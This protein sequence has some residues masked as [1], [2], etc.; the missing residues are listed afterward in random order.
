MDIKTIYWVVASGYLLFGLLLMLFQRREAPSRRV[1]HWV[2][3]K[4]CQ[5][6]GLI[7]L[8][9][10][11]LTPDFFSV[12]LGNS[13]LLSGYAYEAWVLGWISGRVISR[14][15]QR[16]ALAGIL[17]LSF[18]FLWLPMTTRLVLASGFLAAVFGV[19]A[20]ALFN[21]R[22]PKTPISTFLGWSL[23]GMAVIMAVRGLWA[24]FDTPSV[25]PFSA[26]WIHQLGAVSFYYLL[27]TSGLGILLLA[28]RTT[29]LELYTVLNEQ[30][31][32]WQTLPT[33][34]CILRE[35]VVERCNPAMEAIFG[36]APGSLTG[37]SVRVLYRNQAD[38][39]AFGSQIYALIRQDR[40]F[41]GEIPFR[42]K[43]GE[44]FWA[45]VQGRAI[46]PERD[47]S[48]A[49]FS[50]VDVTERVQ[51]ETALRLS[52]GKFKTIL[53]TSPDGIATASL[54]GVLQFATVKLAALLGYEQV[55]ALV[56]LQAFDLIHP[57]DR[58]RL[59]FLLAEL[60]KGHLTGAAEA[61]FLRRDGTS[62]VGEVNANLLVDAAQQP[63]SILC[64]VR[65]ITE[66]KQAEAALRLHSI[67]IENIAEG[68]FLVRARDAE[69]L[70]ANPQFEKMFGYAPG[71][72]VGMNVSRLNAPTELSP[73]ATA[74]EIQA[75]LRENGAWSGEVYNIKKDGTLFWC[76]ANVS[77]FVHPEYGTVW[78]AAHQDITERKQA[79]QAVRDIE[80][81]FILLAESMP[82]IVWVCQPDGKNIYFNQQWVDYT[83]LT[84]EE[85][86]GHGWVKPFHPD[87]Q[88]RAWDAWQNAVTHG[89]EYA[90]E[91]RLRRADGAYTW[92]LV[93]G[94]PYQAADGTTLKWFG[95][96][97][98]IQKL[99]EVETAL[100]ES[101]ERFRS[102][103]DSQ[104][105]NILVLDF[106][107]IHHYVNQ[108]GVAS[109]ASS[110]TAKDILGKR[111]H[112]L[113]S[114][115]VAD[116]QLEQIRQVMATGK[117]FSGD[118]QEGDHPV[119]WWHLN[120]QPIRNASGQVVQVMVNSLDITERKRI[121]NEIRLLNAE[122]E[123][124]VRARTHEL[125]E[126]Q[127]KLL[128]QEKLAILGQ[129]AG[130]VGHELR[131]PLGVIN[132]AI[133]YLR[134]IQPEADR[135]VL[136]YLGMIESETHLA[137]K[138]INDLLD[139]SRSAAVDLEPVAVS[140]L[141]EQ[142]LK[143]FPLPENIQVSLS[144][145]ADLPK[146]LVDPRQLTQVLGNLVLNAGQAMPQG[147]QLVISA[148]QRKA[149]REPGAGGCEPRVESAGQPV[150][151]EPTPPL[152]QDWL[153]ISVRDTG[154]GIPPE[155]LGKLFEPLFT[156]KP[157]GIGLGL[158]VSKKLVEANGGKIEVQ[159]EFGQGS[160]FNLYLP[161]D[162]ARHA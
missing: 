127:E 121:E 32:V 117:G 37:Q 93:R 119:I 153:V 125:R 3:S 28:K 34:L 31:T 116:W 85:S 147:G 18:S 38:Y 87:D 19:T 16:L 124:R 27:L 67:M 54:E 157:K 1:P 29:D 158:A 36:F 111:L 42:R 77:E 132:S 17:V 23:G 9:G 33:G 133:Y 22:G 136:E 58:E 11:G 108:V 103:L 12:A 50:I 151:T 62:F 2:A 128:R 104:E 162:E 82:Q 100:R 45:K 64:V 78:V 13:F 65:N 115:Q 5:A 160:V 96:C 68:I 130:S 161:F 70:Y 80:K 49:V 74:R 43:T 71:E 126:A 150:G 110:G 21:F 60:F 69:I 55:E 143:R 152:S 98:D 59:R 40:V 146:A 46:F 140:Q 79:E 53:E 20:W 7:L 118:F 105:S 30:N 122:L 135:R 114:P 91:V 145:P 99:K 25:T 112:D 141:V 75:S 88:Q 101:E 56:G 15:L 94:V 14:R 73:E 148:E 35:R 24:L 149:K 109:I 120:L 57:D 52:E 66:R 129:L 131:N 155:N 123:E 83:G 142:T 44:L 102:L 86:Y 4:L 139:F 107:G 51:M 92:W 72:L 137:D 134:L 41:E 48:Y 95:T 159:S 8:A 138:I 89:A 39:E 26:S 90:L 76:F 113:Y 61:R 63:V 154:G 6:L 144:L 156:T 10:R 106:D 84:L 47:Q 97:T 81:E